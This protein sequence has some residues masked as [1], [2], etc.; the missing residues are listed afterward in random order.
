MNPEGPGLKAGLTASLF[1]T[2]TSQLL[3]F[4]PGNWCS[5]HLV[6]P[7]YEGG[8]SICYDCA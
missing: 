6:E 4:Y 3:N 8:N 7:P 2:Y 5:E 1:S